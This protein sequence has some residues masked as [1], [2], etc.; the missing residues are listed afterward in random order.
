MT[1][2]TNKHNASALSP[3]VSLRAFPSTAPS[4]DSQSPTRRTSF[5]D[6]EAEIESQVYSS[7]H[8]SLSTNKKEDTS[9]AVSIH[10]LRSSED[11]TST[12]YS[13]DKKAVEEDRV[14]ISSGRTYRGDDEEQDRGWSLGARRAAI[15]AIYAGFF[16]VFM[17]SVGYGFHAISKDIGFLIVPIVVLKF[18]HVAL[19]LI[20]SLIFIYQFLSGT[21]MRKTSSRPMFTF[22]PL[23]VLYIRRVHRILGYTAMAFFLVSIAIG[24][25]IVAHNLY[26]M[27]Q[28]RSGASG[29]E[30][31]QVIANFQTGHTNKKP[32]QVWDFVFTTSGVLF[33]GVYVI[34]CFYMGVQAAKRG[35]IGSH[36]R[37]MAR[38]IV[39]V[40]A[41]WMVY[42]Y[43]FIVTCWIMKK[44]PAMFT[45]LHDDSE[46]SDTVWGIGL[47][48]LLGSSGVFVSLIGVEAVMRILAWKEKRD[49]ERE[50]ER[51]KATD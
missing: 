42:R 45:G 37:L 17:P 16:A 48:R 13:R 49:M 11:T 26:S 8:Y 51:R 29:G 35:D 2:D 14:S 36:V 10:T 24:A 28:Y 3:T 25:A 41:T 40:F 46:W 23:Q 21:I 50:I 43:L 5:N 47:P 9:D 18:W 27:I 12:A 15:L 44:D 38:S 33:T 39:A 7:Y 6:D 19:M 22:L 20:A 31:L 30:N 34:S 4:T 32:S 1:S